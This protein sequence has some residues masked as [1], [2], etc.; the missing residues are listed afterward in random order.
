MNTIPCKRCNK[1]ITKVFNCL[2][3]D[4]KFC[5]NNCMIDHTFESHQQP[6]DNKEKISYRRRSTMKSPFM[7][8]GDFLRDFKDD[9]LYDF[10]NFDFVK[11]GK[12]QQVLGCGAFGD[13]YLAKNK[14]DNKYYAIKQMN[15]NKITEHGAKLDIVVREINVHRRLIHDN[16]V[17]MYS[18]YE[19]KESFYIVS[20]YNDLDHGIH[21]QWDLI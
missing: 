2:K 20:F 9:P 8:F 18:S 4:N 6:N 17:R 13:V 10:K 19:D 11:V 3:C 7:K 12:K 16:I 1:S 14:V 5:S 15:K 21:K